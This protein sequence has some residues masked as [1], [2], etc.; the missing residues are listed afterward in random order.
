MT[1]NHNDD[2]EFEML[3]LKERK[4]SSILLIVAIVLA[5]ATAGS[6]LWAVNKEPASSSQFPSGTPGQDFNGQGGFPGGGQ[7]GPGFGLDVTS[8]FKDDGSVDTDKVDETTSRFPGGG[9]SRFTD[10]MQQRVDQAV[11]DGDIT[12]DQADKLMDA[13][14]TATESSN[15]S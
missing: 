14:S 2:N 4:K 5:V 9:D 11:E 3:Y 8:F 15:A 13:F 10:L 12:Q 7:G 6:V 1:Q